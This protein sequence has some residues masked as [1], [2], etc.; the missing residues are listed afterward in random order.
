[1]TLPPTPRRSTRASRLG[2]AVAALAAAGT[3]AAA[4]A[5][6]GFPAAPAANASASTP[7]STEV[8]VDPTTGQRVVVETVYVVTPAAPP[9]VAPAG[10]HQG[11]EHEGDD[12]HKGDDEHEGGDD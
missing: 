1:M 12:E 6:A 11:D 8:T 10:R 5:I 3:F 7:T 9:A 2:L 4:V